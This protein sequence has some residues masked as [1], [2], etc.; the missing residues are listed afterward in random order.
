MWLD[1]K[2]KTRYDD[3]KSDEEL[4]DDLIYLCIGEEGDRDWPIAAR[5]SNWGG[6]A[7]QNKWKRKERLYYQHEKRQKVWKL[8][9][10][11]V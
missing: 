3:L 5:G 11:A 8:K 4:E 10:P 1:W 7:L 6:I 2:D 9:V